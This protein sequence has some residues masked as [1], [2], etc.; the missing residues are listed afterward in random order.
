MA[1]DPDGSMEKLVNKPKNTRFHQQRLK[2]WRPVLTAKG[3]YPMFLAIGLVFI[4]IGVALLVT[5]NKVFERVFEYTHCERSPAAMVPSRCSE[6]VRAPAFYQNYQSCPCTVSF[7]LDEAVDGQVYFFYGL[8]NFFQNHRRYI[9]SKDDAQLL[10]GTGPLSDACEPY[11]TNPQGVPYA[12][13]G[14]IANSLFNDTFTLKYHG[15]TGSPLAQPV[16]V[17]M[18]N[19]NIA[20]RSD[21]DKKFGQPPASYWGQ[22]VKPDSWP[23][24]AVNRSPEAFRGDE[25]LIVWMRAAALPTFRKL[26]RLIEHTGQFQS[27]LPAGSYSV[28]I[29]YSYPVTQFGGTKRFILSTGSWLGGRNPTLGIAYIVVGSI[30]LALGILFLILHYR[31]PRRVRS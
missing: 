10:G 18:S 20:W 24:P 5:S 27:G 31:L 26:H 16:N 23:V 11:R 9:M 1:E 19:K 8:S 6:E 28:D 22:T 4:P 29:G 3:A 14:A 25:E 15:S 21:V 30:C 7:T 2:S 13:C 12:P 17:P